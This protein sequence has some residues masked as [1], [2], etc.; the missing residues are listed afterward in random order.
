M[1]LLSR[2][3]WL[4]ALLILAPGSVAGEGE[5]VLPEDV[6]GLFAWWD[7]LGYPD[8]GAARFVRVAEADW[9][10]HGDEEPVPVYDYAFLLAD[11]GATFRVFTTDLRLKTLSKTQPSVPEIE[12]VGFD[13]ADLKSF[14]TSGLARMLEPLE[15]PRW[16]YGPDPFGMSRWAIPDHAFRALVLA[17]ACAGRGFVALA[18]NLCDLAVAEQSEW[19]PEAKPTTDRFARLRRS[20]ADEAHVVLLE[21]VPD[22]TCTNEE[23]SA[24]FQRYAKRFPEHPDAEAALHAAA[25]Y[26]SWGAPVEADPGE[27]SEQR[28]DRWIREVQRRPTAVYAFGSPTGEESSERERLLTFEAVP[29]L[30]ARVSSE[31]PTRTLVTYFTGHGQYRDWHRASTLGDL[32]PRMLR[33]IAAGALAEE[34][35]Q[36]E[37]TPAERAAR[38]RARAETWWEGVRAQGEAEVLAATVAAGAE[39]ASS[40]ARRLLVLDLDRGV[41]CVL[42]AVRQAQNPYPAARLIEVLGERPEPV[43]TDALAEVLNSD[44]GPRLRLEAATELHARGVDSA[45]PAMVQEWFHPAKQPIQEDVGLPADP[46][47]LDDLLAFLAKSRDA[48]AYTALAKDLGQMSTYWRFQVMAAFLWLEEPPADPA[49]PEADLSPEAA[50]ALEDLLAVRLE[51]QGEV[52]GVSMSVGGS[53]VDTRIGHVAARA[54]SVQ[55]PSL[56]E[57]DARAPSRVRERMLRNALDRW[58]ARRDLPPLPPP[59]EKPLPPTVPAAIVLPLV[60]RVLDAESEDDRQAAVQA[61]EATGVGAVPVLLEVLEDE[62]DAARKEILARLASRQASIVTHVAFTDDSVEPDAP[63]RALLDGIQGHPFD[64]A[65]YLALMLHVTRTMP[66][67]A[68]GIRVRAARG[69]DLTGVSLRVTILEER[70]DD[71]MNHGGWSYGTPGGGGGVSAYD[72]GL[73]SEAWEDDAEDVDAAFAAPAQKEVVVRFSVVRLVD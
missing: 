27:T 51:D 63:T 53:S 30:I 21:R 59:V 26:A 18:N 67:G 60:Q 61:L 65:F 69:D 52:D 45:V 36:Q 32:V 14:V 64:G 1:R 35:E 12:R 71:G 9:V 70:L 17:R 20:L 56:Y 48:R 2:P 40:A 13:K 23:L 25:V 29:Q 73:K 44:L 68:N 11:E 5:S 39:G 8:V 16:F 58:R 4:A 3:I 41:K 42:E 15:G 38:F 46:G 6:E 10:Q 47:F 54:L 50:R 66:E 55:F 62:G 43:A 34:Y 7:G 19:P 28:V 22:P 31:E 49:H 33:D 72:Y 37:G 57:Y 24:A